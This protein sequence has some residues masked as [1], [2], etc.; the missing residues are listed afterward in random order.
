MAFSDFQQWFEIDPITLVGG[1]AA[2]FPG[3]LMPVSRLLQTSAYAAGLSEEGI[4]DSDPY[5]AHFKPLPGTSMVKNDLARYPFA[6][7]AVAANAIIVQPTNTSFVM[8][9]PAKGAD[10]FMT[11]FSI[12]SGLKQTLARH[13]AL[14]GWYALA[15]PSFFVDGALLL[16]LRDITNYESKQVQAWWQWDFEVPLISQQQA[17]QTQSQ[18][19]SKLSSGTQVLPDQNGRVGWSGVQQSAGQP[20]SQTTTTVLPGSGT[21][22]VYGGA[23]SPNSLS[24]YSGPVL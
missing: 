14:G 1:V 5:F 22:A 21:Q 7:Q 20:N 4:G 24:F 13:S 10:G 16:D 6:N 8:S 15:Q 11:K 23:S 12:M 3:Q 17:A 19:M 2:S 9:C 18:L